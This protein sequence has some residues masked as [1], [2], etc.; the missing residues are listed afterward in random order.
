MLVWN[1]RNK[2]KNKTWHIWDLY[3][4]IPDINKQ[5]KDEQMK[6]QVDQLIIAAKLNALLD[7]RNKLQEEIDELKNKMEDKDE[8]P[9]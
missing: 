7:L 4:I 6:D 3:A 9:F 8:I 1:T 2:H 5:R